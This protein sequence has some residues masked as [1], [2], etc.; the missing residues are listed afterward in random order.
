MFVFTNGC[1]SADKVAALSQGSSQEPRYTEERL[2]AELYRVIDG[3]GSTEENQTDISRLRIEA[4][5]LGLRG[6]A[7]IFNQIAPLLEV[8]GT[9]LRLVH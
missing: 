3:F 8:F 5:Q 4:G 9:A 7:V 2:M 6:K 1:Y